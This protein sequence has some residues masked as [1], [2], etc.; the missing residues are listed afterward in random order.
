[1]SRDTAFILDPS[2]RYLRDSRRV[3]GSMGKRLKLRG[4]DDGRYDG[5]LLPCS[6]L[7]K[8]SFNPRATFDGTIFRLPWRRPEQSDTSKISKASFTAS[9]MCEMLAHFFDQATSTCLFTRNVREISAFR[10]ARD[11]SISQLWS[12]K[13]PDI[14]AISS[15]IGAGLTGYS[16][17]RHSL[18]VLN[19]EAACF[20]TVK[21][22]EWVVTLQDLQPDQSKVLERNLVR[23]LQAGVAARLNRSGASSQ[24]NDQNRK[25][26]DIGR[27]HA[28]LPIPY[29]DLRLP[30]HLHASGIILSSDRRTPRLDRDADDT[31][32]N[33]ETRVNLWLLQDVLPQLYL[34]AIAEITQFGAEIEGGTFWPTAHSQLPHISQILCQAMLGSYF[35]TYPHP[36]LRDIN[37]RL[38]RPSEAVI[39]KGTTGDVA[40]SSRR[41]MRALA[42]DSYVTPAPFNVRL[43]PDA[44]WAAIRTD[45]A[46]F[47]QQM[48]LLHRD[49][50]LQLFNGSNIKWEDI[51]NLA[52]FLLASL[53]P[54]NLVGLPLLPT[55]DGQLR[56]LGSSSDTPIF[57]G[58]SYA[59]R[60]LFG[61]LAPQCIANATLSTA[62]LK[63]LTQ[64][65][66][67]N[68]R[69]AGEGMASH[70]LTERFRAAETTTM[71]SMLCGSQ[72]TTSRSPREWLVSFWGAANKPEITYCDKL[73]IVPV[74]CDS[75]V[76]NVVI[77]PN[78]CRTGPVV[79]MPADAEITSA[80]LQCNRIYV[81][82]P[83]EV[84]AL[85][86]SPF[87]HLQLLE[88]FSKMCVPSH[89]IRANF[90]AD[91]WE[92][93]ASWIARF[94]GAYGT[95]RLARGILELLR[96]LPIWKARTINGE[97]DFYASTEVVVLPEG[98]AMSTAFFK[99]Q[100]LYAQPPPQLRPLLTELSRTTLSL[101]D[102]QQYII[103]PMAIRQDQFDAYKPVFE[104]LLHLCETGISE[105][106]LTRFVPNC[107]GGLVAPSEVSERPSSRMNRQMRLR[108]FVPAIFSSMTTRLG[109][110][111]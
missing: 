15:P 8:W 40:A 104:A 74:H 75:K 5:Q 99:P 41:I 25:A 100:T 29:G 12:V 63:T 36:I 50:L 37:G 89:E 13:T 57:F 23:H 20:A 46:Y 49:R 87:S 9:R 70:L 53:T 62:N 58:L 90:S 78:F 30:A 71:P 67:T 6:G 45:D 81:V 69:P 14:Q 26:Q 72:D 82:D 95:K 92:Q 64:S 2:R 38:V 80:L 42:V 32:R 7:S 109:S 65:A 47:V 66:H 54:Q 76:A 43:V 21:R 111:R 59:Q 103:L 27:L 98:V 34:H 61:Q 24:T 31:P 4:V 79:S 94:C 73:A 19:S 85:R 83:A 102:L 51:D 68:L 93:L 97:E 91:S 11:G 86:L 106:Y 55:I 107:R 88:C 56:F 48:L 96:V 28:T 52:T 101:R 77:S 35:P 39:S 10:R 16:S 84:P 33:E 105:L 17:R 44:A 22:E 60:E 110:L 18:D 1:M 3:N 108:P